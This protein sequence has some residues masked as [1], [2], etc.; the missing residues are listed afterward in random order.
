MGM[1][2][3]TKKKIESFHSLVLC[4]L[5]LEGDL[6][7]A[8]LHY[9]L[10]DFDIA[11]LPHY[12][13]LNA[14]IDAIN[15]HAEVSIGI[16]FVTYCKRLRKGIEACR[17]PH[18][19]ASFM[20]PLWDEHSTHNFLMKVGNNGKALSLLF[21]YYEQSGISSDVDAMMANSFKDH[22]TGLFNRRTMKSH[23]EE[24]AKDGYLCL[25]DL[26]KFKAIN[27]TFGHNVGDEVLVAIGKYL[28]A[29]SSENEVFYR[30]SGDEF[31]ILFL[32]PDYE[33]AVSLINRI[34]AFLE[35][36]PQN[37]LKG[38]EGLE[39][40]A[41]FGLLELKYPQGEEPLPGEVALSLTDLAMYQAKTAKKRLHYISH[42]DALSIVGK[43]DLQ[44]RL[45]A[46][47]ASISR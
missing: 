28:I 35:Q 4:D 12:R 18:H 20:L 40:S 11:G 32:K 14:V 47:A 44:Q 21:F 33:Y 7:S 45:N 3:D 37:E 16:G 22:L 36:L 15:P 19:E 29:I 1:D 13:T 26:N 6:F 25:F 46:L 24:N 39:C 10:G 43:G 31:M 38:H 42:E 17:K 5:P 30:R 23:V 2:N 27:D 41:S 8:P 9:L 34:E